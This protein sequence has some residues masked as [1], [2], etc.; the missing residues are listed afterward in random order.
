M[1]DF[2][3]IIARLEKAGEADRE[4]D[5]DIAMRL[6]RPFG[7]WESFQKYD[8]AFPA[9]TRRDAPAYTASID[10]A[11]ELV[12]EEANS[13]G[14]ELQRGLVEAFVSRNNV[15]AGHWYAGGEHPTS[16]AIALCIAVLKAR[17]AISDEN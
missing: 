6:N 14:Y 10:A 15:K 8:A 16:P 4:L 5:F 9:Y 1:S 2:A 11:L 13:H 17:A 7:A 3:D 12:P